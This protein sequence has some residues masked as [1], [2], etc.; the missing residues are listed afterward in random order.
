MLVMLGL[1]DARRKVVQ[2][3]VEQGGVW[4]MG[5]GFR[6]FLPVTAHC[7]IGVCGGARPSIAP[8]SSHSTSLAQFGTNAVDFFIRLLFSSLTASTVCHEVV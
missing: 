1:S 4:S 6:L 3:T 7:N 5:V 2:G 8:I